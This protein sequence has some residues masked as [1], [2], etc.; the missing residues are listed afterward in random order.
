MKELIEKAASRHTEGNPF[1]FVGEYFKIGANFVLDHLW[2]EDTD[3]E[4]L[5]PPIE[6]PVFVLK[7]VDWTGISVAFRVMHG[8]GKAGW[9]IP[10]VKYF[11]NVGLPKD[12]K[13]NT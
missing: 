7:E 2:Q 3:D 6:K 12:K 13:S 10:D 5:L 9:N 8:Y 4:S 11:L 1:P